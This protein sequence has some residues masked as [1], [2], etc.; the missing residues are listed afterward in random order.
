MRCRRP[1]PAAPHWGRRWQRK[2]GSCRETVLPLGVSGRQH[3]GMAMGEAVLAMISGLGGAGLAGG[4]TLWIQQMKRRDDAAAASI[5]AERAE[6][7]AVA[8]ATRAEQSAAL[9]AERA[10]RQ[11]AADLERAEAKTALEVLATA[12][13]ALRAWSTHLQ[14]VLTALRSQA[15]VDAVEYRQQVSADIRELSGALYRI[16]PIAYPAPDQ[17]SGGR[18]GPF[19][20]EVEHVSMQVQVLVADRASISTEDVA[21][22]ARAVRDTFKHASGFLVAAAEQVSGVAVPSQTR[23]SERRPSRPLGRD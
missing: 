1:F 23:S 6:A 18:R 3:R 12:R 21:R 16:P 5:A 2:P 11:A 7:A 13:V 15:D 9:A 10:A 19:V 20:T 4:A 17:Y 14:H 22:Q 8:A